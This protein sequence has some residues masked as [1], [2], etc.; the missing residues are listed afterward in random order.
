MYGGA[1]G[2]DAKNP[3]GGIGEYACEGGQKNQPTHITIQTQYKT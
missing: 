3:C 2:L 1:W